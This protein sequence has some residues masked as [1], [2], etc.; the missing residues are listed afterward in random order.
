[1]RAFLILLALCIAVPA[2]HTAEAQ[3][4]NRAQ[5]LKAKIRAF[6]TAALINRIGLDENDVGKVLPIINGY[7]DQ[8][9][10]LAEERQKL[11]QK[12]Q[13]A[14]DDKTIDAALDDLVKNQRAIWDLDE[15]RFADVRAVLT[16][17]QAAKAL[18][19][20]PNLDRQIMNRL[21]KGAAGKAAASGDDDDT[22]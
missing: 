1:M 22:E 14:T 2:V 11:R 21:K 8:F 20:L 10:K 19:V 15:K 3:K 4:N 16:P 5:K 17:A 6:R 18:I 13:N 12:V 9:A 7:D